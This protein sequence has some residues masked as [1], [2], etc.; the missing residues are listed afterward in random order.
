MSEHVTASGLLTEKDVKRLTRLTRG[1]TV[2]PTAVYYAGVTA[3]VI[4][5]GM[6]LLTRTAFEHIGMSEYW[7][8]LLSALIAAFAGITWYLIFIRWSYRHRYG[9]GTEMTIETNIKAGAEGITVRR[10][11]ISTNIGWSAVESIEITRGHMALTIDGAD[12]LIIPD[13]WFGQDKTARR[14]FHAAIQEWSKPA[15]GPAQT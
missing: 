6:G 2:G 5:A 9:R 11:D 10:G 4:S 13:K 8:W 15:N 12:A 3:P 14:A 7:Q 1:G